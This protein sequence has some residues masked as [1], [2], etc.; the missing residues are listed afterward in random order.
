M[1]YGSRRVVASA[2][3]KVVASM[4]VA[5]M[6]GRSAA[7]GD[8]DVDSESLGCLT[9]PR[10]FPVARIMR[11]L[12]EVGK[13]PFTMTLPLGT[14]AARAIASMTGLL[15]M[16]LTSSMSHVMFLRVRRTLMRLV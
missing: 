2:S 16:P 15:A 5:Q 13:I 14:P 3:L 12:E 7:A 6:V 10:N 9:S 4:I 11:L 1:R 8:G